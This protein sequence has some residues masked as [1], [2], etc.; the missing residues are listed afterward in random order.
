M[1]ED[2]HHAEGGKPHAFA[3]RVKFV[4]GKDDKVIGVDG[5]SV[6]DGAAHGVMAEAHVSVG[7]QKPIASCVL[8]ANIHGVRLAEPAGGKLGDVENL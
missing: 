6:G 3:N 8:P 7:E 5:F 4:A 1:A 2:K